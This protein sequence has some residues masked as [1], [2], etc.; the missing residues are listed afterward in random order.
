MASAK[1]AWIVIEHNRGANPGGTQCACILQCQRHNCRMRILIL[2]AHPKFSA[3][4]VQRTMHA[5]VANLESVTIHDLYAAYP[6]LAIDVAREQEL[7]LAHDV[8]ILQHPFYW[9]SSPAILKE[10]QDLVLEDGWAYGQDGTQLAGKFMLS[11]ISTGGSDDAY[12]HEG[13]NRF[14]IA[15]LLSP[16]NQTAYLCS[17]AYLNPFIIHA[18][19]RMTSEHLSAGAERYRDLIVDLRDRQVEPLSL[20]APGFT[21]PPHFGPGAR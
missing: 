6:D 15:E 5:A 13:R 3:S 4:V 7:L 11:A 17:M 16:F 19:R 14:T 9:Y 21:L 10:W 18:G 2:F 8:I 20:L 12:H 1:L